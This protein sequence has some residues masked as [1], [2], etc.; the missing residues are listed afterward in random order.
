MSL[1]PVLPDPATVHPP[2]LAAAALEHSEYGVI[3]QDSE[4][5][6]VHANA[7]ACTLLRLAPEELTQAALQHPDWLAI[8]AQG[9][10]L[11]RQALPPSLAAQ[12]GGVHRE[13]LGLY[14]LHKRHFLWLAVTSVADAAM[15]GVPGSVLTLIRDRGDDIRNHYL[16][17]RLQSLTDTGVWEWDRSQDSFYLSQSALRILGLE[18]PPQNLDAFLA[19]FAHYDGRRLANTLAQP[20]TLHNL[21]SLEL[22]LATTHGNIHWVRLRG[23][24]NM[25][26]PSSDLFNGTI[27]DIDSSKRIERDLRQQAQTDP[28]TGLL[29]RNAISDELQARLAGSAPRLAVLYIDLDRFKIVNDALGHAVGDELLCQVAQRLR[30]ACG[31]EALSARLGGDEF[32]VLCRAHDPDAPVQLAERILHTLTQVFAVSGET[33]SVSASIGIA[34][35]PEDGGDAQ[36]LIHNADAAMYASK[37]RSGGQWQRYSDALALRQSE[38][39]QMDALLRTAVE[40]GEIRLY[41]QPQVALQSGRMCSAEVLLRWDSPVLGTVPPTLFIPRAEHNGL[42]NPLGRWVLRQT[43]M[44]QRHWLDAGLNVV[45]LAVNVSY[46]QFLAGDLAH[47]VAEVLEEAR[48]PGN[49]LELELTERVLMENDPAT[50]GTLQQLRKMGVSLSIDDF[51]EGYSALSYLRHLPITGLKLSQQF[52]QGIPGNRTDSA[53]CKAVAD[54]SRALHLDLVAEG[55][56]NLHQRDFLLSLGVPQAQGFLFAP[57]QDFEKFAQSLQNPQLIPAAASP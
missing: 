2:S 30:L 4:G 39:L 50:L 16:F 47:L 11:S 42:I 45:P 46:R 26:N 17:E 48:I 29:N 25:L 20:G 52:L 36:T 53:I 13:T 43:C 7:R 5:Q 19:C 14:H 6:V 3:L 34:C 31:D 24:A 56:E 27:E 40:N 38:H 55:V 15:P 37:R 41:Y 57:P 44:Q 22:R 49:L 33:L 18:S 8:T 54:L 23:E 32:L 1:P 9:A 35:A 28:L 51:G 21:F 10:P 12:H